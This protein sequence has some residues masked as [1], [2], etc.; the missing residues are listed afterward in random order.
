MARSPVRSVRSVRR[1]ARH[2]PFTQAPLLRVATL[3][4]VQVSVNLFG[5]KP[6]RAVSDAELAWRT[7]FWRERRRRRFFR[8]PV[9]NLIETI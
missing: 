4:L 8:G 9:L 2:A 1:D 5:L 6:L 3:R 7:G